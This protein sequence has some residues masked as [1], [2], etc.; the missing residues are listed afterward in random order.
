MPK[1]DKKEGVQAMKQDIRNFCLSIAGHSIAVH[2]LYTRVFCL[3]RKYLTDEPPE[4]EITIVESDI[5]AE[6]TEN[7]EQKTKAYKGY[8]ETLAVYR[9]I[10]EAM[11]DYDTFLMHGA[12][13]GVGEESYMFTAVSGTGKT[14]HI[15]KWLHNL[16]DAYVVNGDKPLIKIADN[17]AIACATPWRGKE[18][19]GRNCMVPLKAIIL[20]ERGENNKIEKISFEKAISFIVQ[21]TYMPADIVKM[22]KTLALVSKL[23]GRV[24]F[25]KFIFN[26]MKDDAFVVS[27][28]AIVED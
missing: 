9:K 7:K 8:L 21:Q 19:Y 4:K 3:C 18:K 27:Y 6:D 28:K 23:K 13:I 12:V 26:N 14:T 24:K 15:Q 16:K 5:E 22:K 2:A 10:S 25:Y 17:E 1:L 11:L 20:M